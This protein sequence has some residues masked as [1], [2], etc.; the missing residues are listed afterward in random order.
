LRIIVPWSVGIEILVKWLLVLGL[1]DLFFPL[2]SIP[3]NS[4][5]KWCDVFAVVGFPGA[6]WVYA[7]YSDRLAPVI[8]YGLLA[9]SVCLFGAT[10]LPISLYYGSRGGFRELSLAREVFLV[11]VPVL[12]ALV[13]SG[14]FALR[15]F[16]DRGDEKHDA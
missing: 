14:L 16:W 3:H 2:R 6:A 12:M 15:R 13:C 4:L 5:E 1:A 7:G 8:C 11:S 9:G 10:T